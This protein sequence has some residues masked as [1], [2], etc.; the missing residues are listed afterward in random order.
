MHR[1][2]L[3]AFYC[4]VTL[5]LACSQVPARLQSYPFYGQSIERRGKGDKAGPRTQPTKP[6]ADITMP[7]KSR[8]DTAG[9]SRQPSEPTLEIARKRP[10]SPPPRKGALRGYSFSEYVYDP[11][12]PPETLSLQGFRKPL[13]RPTSAPTTRP[14]QLIQLPLSKPLTPLRSI[15]ILKPLSMVSHSK[16]SAM[17][18]GHG[19][20]SMFVRSNGFEHFVDVSPGKTK[21]LSIGSDDH[22]VAAQARSWGGSVTASS[23]WNI[24]TGFF[25]SRGGTG[26]AREAS[27]GTKMN[28]QSLVKS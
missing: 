6:T 14:N 2:F 7:S 20:A 11:S 9:T 3:I 22:D 26:Y 23:T 27:L 16:Q 24:I 19:P 4:L 17:I 28:G 8:T 15:K 10:D 13:R 18:L 5:V 12:A 1:A 25:M 21:A